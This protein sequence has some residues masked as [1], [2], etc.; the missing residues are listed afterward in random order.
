MFTTAV[1][2]AVAAVAVVMAVAVVVT[3]AVEMAVTVAVV[4][5]V[6]VP[7]AVVE[8]TLLAWALFIHH[9][10]LSREL[11]FDPYK[12]DL[13]MHTSLFQNLKAKT[14][15]SIITGSEMEQ[16]TTQAKKGCETC[17]KKAILFLW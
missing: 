14:F 10:I 12:N 6:P 13:F 16:Q 5:P 11:F 15:K 17:F 7:V 1:A 2:V 4:V 9:V 3:A 8:A